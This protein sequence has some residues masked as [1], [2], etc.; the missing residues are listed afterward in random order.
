MKGEF[1]RSTFSARMR[2]GS[3]S[4][5]Q[6]RVQLDTDWNEKSELQLHPGLIY[7]DVWERDVRGPEDN[8][9][10]STASGGP[11]SGSRDGAPGSDDHGMRMIREVAQDG[12][13][14]AT[15]H[16]ALG[17]ATAR[18]GERFVLPELEVSVEGFPWKKVGSL[19]GSGPRDCVYVLTEEGDRASIT[20]GDGKNG[21][22]PAAGSRIVASY[23]FG[24]G[25]SA[26]DLHGHR[27]PGKPRKP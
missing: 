13:V 7:L 15:L 3:V 17:R 18:S 1:S 27:R 2:Y 11:D 10:R 22:R 21:A 26:P 19:T 9:L 4:M 12:R 14:S 23:R 25:G 6:G 16:A 8:S 24:T 20:F 5:Q